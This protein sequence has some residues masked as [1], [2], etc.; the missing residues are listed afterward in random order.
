MFDARL[1]LSVCVC[2]TF[3]SK[4]T[5]KWSLNW[6]HPAF[7][8]WF[9]ISTSAVAIVQSINEYEH[10]TSRTLW[11]CRTHVCWFLL[12]C[13]RIPNVLKISS[14]YRPPWSV[15]PLWHHLLM[16]EFQSPTRTVFLLSSYPF[17]MTSE[18]ASYAAVILSTSSVLTGR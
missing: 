7:T 2:S 16:C 10:S 15:S 6:S 14:I 9:R 5:G 8:E 18:T 4:L 13:I 3:A 11:M 12:L 17:I 1:T